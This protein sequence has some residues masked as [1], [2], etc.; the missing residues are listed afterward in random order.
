MRLADDI[1]DIV[2]L[3]LPGRIELALDFALE[4]LDL[5]AGDKPNVEFRLLVLCMYV[6]SSLSAAIC[7]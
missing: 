3:A 2:D 4:G 7:S 1:I 5:L 6:E